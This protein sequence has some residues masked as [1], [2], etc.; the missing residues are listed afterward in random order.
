MWN[1]KHSTR[2][3]TSALTLGARLNYSLEA[4]K[5]GLGTL[6]REAIV[7]IGSGPNTLPHRVLGRGTTT[8]RI[9]L[10]LSPLHG[11]RRKVMRGV[12]DE[13]ERVGLPQPA[14]TSPP[15]LLPRGLKGH[16]K[17]IVFVVV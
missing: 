5:C 4:H 10:L 12:V 3:Q 17:K 7:I 9:R 6:T 11:T 14:P 15:P 8:R 1:N 16:D 13:V 2:G